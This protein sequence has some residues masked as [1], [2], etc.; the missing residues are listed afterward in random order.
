MQ[1]QVL[2][3]LFGGPAGNL[4]AT[5]SGGH[6]ADGKTGLDF[7]AILQSVTQVSQQSSPDMETVNSAGANLPTGL[8]LPLTE[9]DGQAEDPG[10][11][12]NVDG[13]MP[14]MTDTVLT[15]LFALQPATAEL[16]PGEVQTQG[17]SINSGTSSG[18][19][20]PDPGLIAGI[21]GAEVPDNEMIL[22]GPGDNGQNFGGMK[23]E[24][25]RETT[26]GAVWKPNRSTETANPQGQDQ[27][28][29]GE[30]PS[31][32]NPM[33]DKAGLHTPGS[34]EPVQHRQLIAAEMEKHHGVKMS[35]PDRNDG[36][37]TET[38]QAQSISPPMKQPF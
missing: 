27:I 21:N 2:L 6:T 37:A 15:G 7:A 1:A 13:I 29:R 12:L 26:N 4:Q 38:P 35:V 19:A 8:V 11:L 9:T 25:N 33:G 36:I 16:A 31:R 32:G 30:A 17:I 28:W 5:K 20:E 23:Q 10:P 18:T 24:T 22:P 14:E 3:P 34:G